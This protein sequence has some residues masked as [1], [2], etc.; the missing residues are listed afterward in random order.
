MTTGR[1]LIVD[2]E[3]SWR[4]IL[5]EDLSLHG[6]EV[7]TAANRKEA[8][9]QLASTVF[10]LLVVDLRLEAS[11]ATDVGG[12]EI[13]RQIKVQRPQS[14]IRCIVCTAFGTHSQMREGFRDL[15]VEGFVRKQDFEESAF[16]ELVRRLLKRE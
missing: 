5:A 8:A 4:Y 7:V 11:D 14:A 13:L 10:D 2:D 6:F 9:E 15:G 12:M 3:E 1:I 16:I